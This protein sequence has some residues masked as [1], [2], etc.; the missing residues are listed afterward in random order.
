MA[1]KDLLV[2]LDGS[3]QAEA[4][5]ALAAAVARQHG[6][7]LTGLCVTDPSYP[8]AL[9]SGQA[10]FADAGTLDLL[11]RRAREEMREQAARHEQAF[12][13][14]AR[15]EGVAAA[16]RVVE[17]DLAETVAVQARSADIVVVSQPDPSDPEAEGGDAV[18]E[19]VLFASG[20]PVLLA[21]W[22]GR[23]ASGIRNVLVAWKS[24][25]ESA[26]ALHDAMPLIEQAQSVTVLTIG[27]RPGGAARDVPSGAEIAAHLVHHGVPAT[28]VQTEPPGTGVGDAILNHA[29]ES[30]ADLLVMGAYGHSRVRELVLGG[31]TRTILRHM[32]LPVLMSH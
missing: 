6:S 10:R 7:H 11:V 26:R 17:G 29:S 8:L 21:P 19:R 9:R 5:L 14:H 28:A 4:R 12:L 23:F 25:R 1:L 13:E 16:W 15:R 3:A 24:T 32:T 18:V 31:V 20:R 30:G 2:Y 22:A 27:P